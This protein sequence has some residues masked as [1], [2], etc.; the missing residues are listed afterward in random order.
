MPDPVERLR[1]MA[2][3]TTCVRLVIDTDT[4]NEVD[5]QFALAYALRSVEH[6]SVEAIYA[7]PFHNDRSAGPADGMLRSFDEIHRVL[8]RMA[9]PSP[10]PVFRGSERFL[11]GKRQPV[12]SE[13]VSNLVE[14]AMATTPTDPPLYIAAIGAITNIASALLIEP[15]IAD[16]IVVI[17]LGGTPGYES[18]ACEFNLQQD[19]EAARVVFDSGVPL[20]WIPCQPVAS[21]LVTTTYELAA[22][23]DQCGDI[24]QYLLQI[25]RE[26]DPKTPAWSKVIWDI[27]APAWLVNA[28]WLPTREVPSPV[29]TDTLT[30]QTEP[31]RHPIRMATYVHRDQVFAN[32][33]AKL[34]VG[35]N[36]CV[37]N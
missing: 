27:A 20:I 2:P 4:Y 13:A 14:R 26:Y 10:P 3:P 17:W 24:G 28:A 6:M 11:L 23:L 33:F 36:I 8:Q 31:D 9:L 22:H 15:A 12:P 18:S 35:A 19:P 29:L 7:A 32:L 34:S 30:W 5:D 16:R 25:V 37:G 1:R 21:H